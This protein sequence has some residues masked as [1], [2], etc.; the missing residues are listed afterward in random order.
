MISKKLYYWAVIVSIFLS[1]GLAQAHEY[2]IEPLA[3]RVTPEQKI[4]AHL[5]IGQGLKGDEL[6]FIPD[7]FVAAR[8][9][10][11]AGKIT[12]NG[13]IGDVPALEVTPKR[14]GLHILTIVTKPN[15][16]SYDKFSKFEIFVKKEGLTGALEAHRKANLPE[17]G[18]TEAYSR[19]AKALVQVG[20][21]KASNNNDT[22]LGMP[23]ELIAEQSP[24]RLSIGATTKL[25]VLLLW[26]G[27]PLAGAQI[28]IFRTLNGKLETGKITTGPE[29]R[30][31][32]P[33]AKAGKYLLNAVHMIRWSEKPNDLWHSYWASLTF[34]A[35]PAN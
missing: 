9:V 24:Y 7:N 13:Q 22:S 27:K 15:R 6:P 32:I 29:G 25:P 4:R 28:S 2:W 26:K 31:Q 10:D 21:P 3:F 30:A 16:L 35:K 18:F 5:K 14:P 20:P 19:Y 17:T 11:P 12:L 8:V 33:L 1:P 34:E 23:I